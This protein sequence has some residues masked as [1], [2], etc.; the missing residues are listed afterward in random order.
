MCGCSAYANGHLPAGRA[1]CH[2]RSGA[3]DRGCTRVHKVINGSCSACRAG[4]RSTRREQWRLSGLLLS[5]PDTGCGTA[6][7]RTASNGLENHRWFAAGGREEAPWLHP[8]SGDAVL[9]GPCGG[10]RL[11]P[12]GHQGGWHGG[13]GSAGT[14]QFE[15]PAAGRRGGVHEPAGPVA[16]CCSGA[17]RA[18]S[19]Q[20]RCTS[21]AS[22][23]PGATCWSSTAWAASGSRRSPGNSKPIRI[24]LAR[25]AGTDFE[26]VVLTIRLALA[27]LGRPLPAF[28]LALR[29]YWEHQH[30]GEP[31]EEYL[32]RG[33]LASR[34]GK[35]LPQQM[36]FALAD[37]AQALLLPGTVGSV[38]GEVTGS[39]VRALRERRQ[40]VRALAG[41]A[42]LADLLQAEPGVDA[43]SYY[44]HLLAWE[45]SRLPAGRRVVPVV[46]LDTFEDIGDRCWRSLKFPRRCSEGD[47]TCSP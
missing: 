7:Y 6:S 30:P 3:P 23:R 18:P 24:D 47:Q 36:Q 45:L 25:A 1:P 8:R 17:H 4:P 2:A 15:R 29:R 10:H 37:V 46:L 14:V 20:R 22:Q 13:R 12:G 35:A 32:R 31:L 34:A 19:A 41:C 43:L 21:R 40:S 27:E 42:R 38:V 5:L 33:G 44:P 9:E 26:R 16:D 39:L 11:V 28:D